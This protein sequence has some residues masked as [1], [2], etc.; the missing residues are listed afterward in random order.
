MGE[1]SII[2]AKFQLSRG[3]NVPERDHLLQAIASI[4][5]DYR[6]DELANPTADHVN[7]WIR[8]FP[9]AVQEPI[10]VEMEHVLRH[11]YFSRHY[12]TQFFSALISYER[13][14]GHDPCAFWRNANFMNLQTAGNS[15]RDLLTI[16]DA[17][18]R[19]QCHF[20][21]NE[22]GQG[23]NTYVYVDDALF[24]GGRIKTDLISWINGPAPLNATV[25]IITIARHMQGHFF[26]EKDLAKASKAA[27]KNVAVRW[28]SRYV[29]E[30]R[31]YYINTSDVLRPTC[32]PTD[33]QTQAYVAGL[34]ADPLLRAA[35]SVGGNAF[36]SSEVGRS[37]LEQE[38]LKIGVWIRQICPNLGV[39]QRPLGNTTHKKVGF[40]STI[41]TFRNCPNNA[42]LALWVDAPWYPLFPRKTN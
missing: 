36:F 28:V 40:G 1:C 13:L 21:L 3:K 33:P 16:F 23:P 30:D 8:Q 39:F 6:R 34:G 24:S 18:L 20:G 14:A 10:L 11:T 4:A 31:N 42:P 26:A 19:E 37:L 38:F 25:F 7:R 9:A 22:C 27:G 5:A 12:V 17:Q 2:E 32:I 35:G 41:V 15:Q 29:I